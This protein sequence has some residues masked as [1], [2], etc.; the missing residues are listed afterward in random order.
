MN[1][2]LKPSPLIA[3][4]LPGYT[5]LGIIAVS[6]FTAHQDQWHSL[7]NSQSLLAVV[8]GLGAAS[9]VASWIIGTVLDSVRDLLEVPLD[10]VWRVNWDFLFTAPESEI[11][12]LH[13]SWLAYY[14][15]TGNYVVGLIL[16]L[17]LNKFGLIKLS[18]LWTWIVWLALLLFAVDACATRSEIRRLMMNTRRCTPRD[19]RLPHEGVYTRLGRSKLH[20]VGVFAIRRIPKGTNPF[21]TDDSKSMWVKQDRIQNLPPQVRE[22]YGD[23]GVLRDGRWC[24]PTNFNKLT[25]GW[26]LNC[27]KD[28]P[29]MACD[30]ALEFYALRDIEEGE[31]L[32]VDYG[33]FSE[34]T[35]G[36][37]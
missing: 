25:P 27:S 30:D 32:T 11:R 35:K 21:E 20:G 24:V 15:L 1:A 8:T 2:S 9:F 6:Y 29:N 12:K 3:E 34:Y 22:L 17:L 28:N 13:D 10:W 18:M 36:C 19:E 14:Y 16:I 4:V 37:E 23:F 31:E 33:T 5:V 26:Y 7:I